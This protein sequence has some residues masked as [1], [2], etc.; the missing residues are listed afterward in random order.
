MPIT[1]WGKVLT[2]A[3]AVIGIPLVFIIL[4]GFGDAISRKLAFQLGVMS[5]T[6]RKLF[7]VES[8]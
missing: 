3:Y 6:G 1:T 7:G 2:M 4:N 5:S 8:Q